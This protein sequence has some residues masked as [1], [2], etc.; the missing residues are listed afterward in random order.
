MSLPDKTTVLKERF[1]EFTQI[2]DSTTLKIL[3]FLYT[4]TNVK[5]IYDAPSKLNIPSTSF[6]RR[7]RS[8]RRKG[9]KFTIALDERKIGLSKVGFFIYDVYI[10]LEGI[11]W[12]HWY[13]VHILSSIPS[14]TYI[15][16]Y[17][18][19]MY[20]YRFIR[21]EIA[22]LSKR[23]KTDFLTIDCTHIFLCQ[24]CFTKYFDVEK[25]RF[26][27]LWREW[28]NEVK[29]ILE[30]NSCEEG[31]DKCKQ[32]F[33]I[34]CRDTPRDWIDLLILKELEMD[35]F[36]TF[37]EIAKHLH[38]RTWIIKYHYYRHIL[39][40]GIIKGI[41]P[42]LLYVDVTNAYVGIIIFK[43]SYAF[44]FKLKMFIDF[45][46]RL[47]FVYA[48]SLSSD[49]RTLLIQVTVP[50]DELIGFFNFRGFLKKYFDVILEFN[51][52][53]RYFRRS[54]LPHTNY[55]PYTG[56]WVKEPSEVTEILEE[57]LGEGGGS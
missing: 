29:I 19:I 27:Y 7:I 26:R 5:T 12:K 56:V 40:E 45:L 46:T 44:G 48:V 16:Y 51:Y 24:P 1:F 53:Y 49:L 21:D 28:I 10:P 57:K 9:I 52:H 43:N 30:D 37:S 14:G 47:P 55:N 3:E 38:T 2:V 34:V 20:G 35:A 33:D 54:T 6:W 4:Q 18:P 13:N 42:K 22:K 23:E 15:L 41:I 25:G 36:Q 39:P 31:E 50:Y 32:V 17:Y 11:P 8:L